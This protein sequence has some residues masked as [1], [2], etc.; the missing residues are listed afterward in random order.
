MKSG[1]AS[2]GAGATITYTLA[3]SNLGPDGADGAAYGDGLPRG[4]VATAAS[5]GGES[6]GASCGSRS[7]IADSSVVGAIEVLPPGGAVVVTITATAPVAEE[8]L[9]NRARIAAPAGTTDP[10]P[11]N[12]SSSV[13]TVVIAQPLQ[14]DLAIVKIGPAS[15]SAGG[16]VAYELSVTNNGPDDAANVTIDDPSPPGLTFVSASSPCAGGFPCALGAL[17]NGAS[18]LVTV[19]FAIDAGAT[20]SVTNTATVSS[21]TADPVVGNNS[22]VAVT[23]IIVGA[24][25]ADLAVGKSGPGS[26]LAGGNVTYQVTVANNGPDA[27][28]NVVL[29]DPAPPGLS[30]IAADAPCA[31]GFPCALGTLASGAS[32]TLGATYTVAIDAGGTTVVNTAAATS[33]TADPEG[34]NDAASVTTVIAPVVGASA[35]L[36][37]RKT[38]PASVDVGAIVTYTIAV[39]NNGPD[40]AVNAMLGDPTPSGL[41][42]LDASAPCA[43]GFPCAVG[44][45]A[46]GAGV[47][48]TARFQVNLGAPSQ[49][50]N[51]ATATSDTSDPDGANSSSSALTTVIPGVGVTVQSVP[52][53][54]RWSLL[55]IGL[56]L[57]GGLVMVRKRLTGRSR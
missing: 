42:F 30:L 50:I 19:T 47:T 52:T 27:A 56:L 12:D 31:S 49:V 32:V 28:V 51:T 23:P 20:G 10:D 6:G 15:A 18:T 24:S 14:A 8:T 33:D 29:V 22:G 53:G 17:A 38:G 25:S 34:N 4:L 46:N 7:V 5:C 16:N 26:V 21:D 13:D 48:V 44:D 55:L 54:G 2:V 35:D 37:V 3:I 40:A 57:L 9:T 45:L 1:P 39:T 11:A 41:V 43:G 36:A